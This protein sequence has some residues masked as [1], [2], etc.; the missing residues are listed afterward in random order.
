MRRVVGA[1][2][3]GVEAIAHHIGVVDVA[4]L[5]EQGCPTLRAQ[6]SWQCTKLTEHNATENIAAVMHGYSKHLRLTNEEL[7]RL[8]AILDMRA[9]WLECL[10]FRMTVNDG[11]IPAMDEGWV[12]SDSR[13]HVERV[14]AQ[15]IAAARN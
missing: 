6:A 5:A 10:G 2:G 9:L 15:A 8:P 13:E 12:R 14:A 11:R 4:A 3:P 7:H 1:Q